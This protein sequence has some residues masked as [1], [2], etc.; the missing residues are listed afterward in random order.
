MG[1]GRSG[2]AP[3]RMIFGGFSRKEEDE[4][5]R[6]EDFTAK[7]VAPTDRKYHKPWVVI[8]VPK[9]PPHMDSDSVTPVEE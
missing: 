7:R 9:Q 4:P 1:V 5:K 6:V 8:R 2:I 3:Q